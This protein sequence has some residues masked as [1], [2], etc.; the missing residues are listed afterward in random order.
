MRHWLCSVIVFGAVVIDPMASC[1]AQDATTE[2][3]SAV[4]ERGAQ[5]GLRWGAFRLLPSLILSVTDDDN[6]YARRSDESRDTSSRC[7]RRSQCS[8]TGANTP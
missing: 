7:R 2:A 4:A 3:T 5:D 8:R 1:L 6:I